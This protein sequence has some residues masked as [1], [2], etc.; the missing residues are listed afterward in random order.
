MRRINLFSYGMMSLFKLAVRVLVI[1]LAVTLLRQARPA[2]PAPSY[3]PRFDR[4]A[5]PEADIATP[6]SPEESNAA[7]PSPDWR[8]F[9]LEYHN[10]TDDPAQVTDYTI[11]I[12]GLRRDLDFLRDRGYITILPRELAAGQLDDGAPLPQKAVLLTFDDGYV[13]NFTLALPLLREYG[14]KAAVSLI[15]ARIDE[16]TSGFLSWDECREMAKSGLVEF[17]SHTHDHHIHNDANGIERRNGESEDDYLT[18]ISYDLET[19]ITRIRLETGQPVTAFTYPL[20]KM[21]PWAEPVLQQLFSV[22]FS[23]VYG[24]ARYGNS[25]YHLPRFNISDSHPVSEY[26][27]RA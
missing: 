27:R 14:A 10:F 12:S 26:M 18:R 25:L 8:F 15:T 11:T 24:K 3:P 6:S 22:T 19:S 23:G 2:Q 16:G 1:V 17:A 9:V 7:K 20:G 13:S 4:C 21:E 5:M